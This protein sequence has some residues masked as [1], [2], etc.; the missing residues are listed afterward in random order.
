M[1]CAL[2]EGALPNPISGLFIVRGLILSGLLVKPLVPNP[3]HSRI[4]ST[5]PAGSYIVLDEASQKPSK[6]TARPVR[7][8]TAADIHY[9]QYPQ[10]VSFPGNSSLMCLLEFLIPRH[11]YKSFVLCESVPTWDLCRGFLESKALRPNEPWAKFL[12]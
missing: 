11:I 6:C 12:T 1:L 3:Q 5:N 8:L 2:L 4:P 9:P 10:Y 7:T